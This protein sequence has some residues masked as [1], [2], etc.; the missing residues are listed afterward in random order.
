MTVL[1]PRKEPKTRKQGLEEMLRIAKKDRAKALRAFRDV[2]RKLTKLD[3]NIL[4]LEKKLEKK[5]G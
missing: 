2:E 3:A 1:P 5:R 4:S